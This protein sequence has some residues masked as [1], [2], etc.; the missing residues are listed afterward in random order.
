[1]TLMCR[2]MRVGRARTAI[3]DKDDTRAMGCC[4][5][6]VCTASAVAAS[7]WGLEPLFRPSGV[8][9]IDPIFSGPRPQ[10]LRDGTNA[11]QRLDDG[12]HMGVQGSSNTAA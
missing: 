4:G 3:D 10:V 1:M 11:A 5:I 12:L 6:S 2:G 8:H 7:C 9:G